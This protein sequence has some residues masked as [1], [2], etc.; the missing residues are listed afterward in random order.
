MIASWRM[1]SFGLIV[2]CGG[3]CAHLV[4]TKAIQKFSAGLKEKDPEKA[5]ADLKAST[6]EDFASRALRT[7]DSLEDLEIL[8]IPD[9]KISVVKV[10]ELGVD[11]KRVTVAVGE[12]KKE[13][14]YELTKNSSGKWVVDDIYLRQKKQ[15]VEAYKAVSE[16]MDLLL[17][18]R[19]FLDAWDSGEREDVL[20]GT[21]P[22]LRSAL[23]ALPPAYLARMTKKISRGRG[24]SKAQR[25]QAQLT[26][27]T[28]VVRL[29]RSTGE[30]LITLNLQNNRWL[31]SDVLVKSKDESEGL[32]SLYR[33]A[34][35][36]EQ[37]LRFLAAYDRVDRTALANLCSADFYEGSLSL[38]NLKEVRLPSPILT[39]HDLTATLNGMRAD[40]TFRNDR[41]I[42]HVTLHRKQE[43]DLAERPQF[44]VSNVSIYDIASQQEM[45]LGALFTS[46][47]MGE[48]YLQALADRDVAKLRHSSTKDFSNRV[49]QHMN[50][51]LI[52]TA[53]LEPFD[54]PPAKITQIHFEGPLA[55]LTAQAGEHQVE[56]LLREE[57]GRFLVDDIRWD[58]PGRPATAKATLEL[59]LPVRRFALGISLG[60]DP[61]D[62]AE[63]LATL[64][65]SSSRDFNRL[66]WSQTEFVPNSGLSADTFLNAPLKS[67]TMSDGQ[68]IV[69]LGDN[70]FGAV[71][72]MIKEQHR[73]AVDEVLLIAG[74]QPADRLS[75]K[76]ELR[77]QLA[78]G[79]ARPLATIQ[80]ASATARPTS[81][82]AQVVHA[83][84]ASEAPPARPV[85][86]RE[87]PPPD[88]AAP[89][90]QWDHLG[91][92]QTEPDVN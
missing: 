67:M 75:M 53:P 63:A 37:A 88:D 57:T 91:E 83:D 66:V 17:T 79:L 68:V 80:Q 13:V 59:I 19:E 18:V 32:P 64:Q 60:R 82:T 4:E 70:R 14:F 23:E 3:G 73:Y 48:F 54:G 87:L 22:E 85:P 56:L 86:P 71:V 12:A 65:E 44:H 24:A 30:L 36:V 78:R 9:G 77:T 38:G 92:V 28:A 27:D 62:Q 50:E 58:L 21:T 25:P 31:V 2:V 40:L 42:V 1:L 52:A 45:R 39:D 46:R 34:V 51:A 33:E 84:F 8:R 43:E 61:E 72:T 35:A 76:Q 16:Q 55:R 10:E 74:P 5:L 7:A 69:Q 20:R 90:E 6:S 81:N 15:G 49:W 47:A 26:E 41:E 29:P 11:H 89:L